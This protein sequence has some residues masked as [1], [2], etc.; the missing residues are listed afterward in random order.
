[1]VIARRELHRWAKEAEA[2]AEDGTAARQEPAP[3]ETAKA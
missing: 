2:A 1:M 3:K